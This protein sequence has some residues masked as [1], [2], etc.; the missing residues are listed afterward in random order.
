MITADL[1][2]PKIDDQ[3]WQVENA[4]NS[5]QYGPANESKLVT[6]NERW[7]KDPINLSALQSINGDVNLAIK[8]L[9]LSDVDAS[10]VKIHLML[11]KGI[12]VLKNI[13]A[14]AFDGSLVLT[15]TLNSVTTQ[16]VAETKVSNVN[17]VKIPGVKGSALKSGTLNFSGSFTTKALS[18]HSI[19]HQLNGNANLNVTKGAV[20]GVDIKQFISDLK[21]TKDI[22]GLSKLKESLDR[23]ADIAFNHVRGDIKFTNGVARTDNF[24]ID[25]NEG[26][27]ASAGT[28]DLPNWLLALKS[29]LT[30]RNAK[31]IPSLSVNITGSIDHPEFGLDMN[32][33]QK[34]LIQ[35]ATN[36]LTDRA[37]DV[38]K[39]KVTEQLSGAIKG[40]AGDA[41]SGKVGGEVAKAVGKILPGLFG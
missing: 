14:N 36:Q 9:K 22:S 29:N 21:I 2:V 12:A 16:L 17:V 41:V 15:G 35:L 23:K 19:V 28:I 27:I 13:S 18:V 5:T 1:M 4:P 37:Q 38:V 34:A 40:Q 24:D 6:S 25:L 32:Q 3:D 39:K 31:N 8:S 7:S 30:V 33:L 26:V 10:N 20:E 11:N